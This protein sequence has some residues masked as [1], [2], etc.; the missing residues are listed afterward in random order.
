V[1]AVLSG[2]EV[3]G[4]GFLPLSPIKDSDEE[5]DER[6]GSV[7]D[8]ESVNGVLTSGFGILL[9]HLHAARLEIIA[10]SFLPQ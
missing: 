1:V 5:V 2:V 10:V 3:R 4:A 7:N 9:S 8:N 6:R